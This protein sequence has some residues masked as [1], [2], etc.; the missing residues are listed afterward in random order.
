MQALFSIFSKNRKI[1]VR[2]RFFRSECPVA[3]PENGYNFAVLADAVD[4]HAVAA[5]HEVLVD[6]G[7]IDAQRPALVQRLILEILDGVGKAHAQR[8][9]AGGV[10]SNRVL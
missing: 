5:D 1:V 7:I 4:V 6:H 9:M 10:S 8:Q 3:V 2:Q